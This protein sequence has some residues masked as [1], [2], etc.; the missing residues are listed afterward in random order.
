MLYNP[1]HTVRDLLLRAAALMEE[2]GHAS[3]VIED[4]R[5]RVCLLGALSLAHSGSAFNSFGIDYP[6]CARALG[7]DT[8]GRAVEWNNALGR[9]KD[10]V[11]S[12]L[13]AAAAC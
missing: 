13:R 4:D 1:K 3:R 10:E 2:R 7:F 5:G 11:V 8:I 12:A 9:T 6:G